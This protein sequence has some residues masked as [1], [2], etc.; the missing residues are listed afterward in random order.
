MSF[1]TYV[2]EEHELWLKRLEALCAPVEELELLEGHPQVL[3]HETEKLR[4]ELR[5]YHVFALENARD[6]VV[7]LVCE[8][9]L[10]LS[11]QSRVR[12]AFDSLRAAQEVELYEVLRSLRPAPDEPPIPKAADL[13]EPLLL[14]IAQRLEPFAPKIKAFNRL[15][16]QKERHQH[17][18]ETR[19][20]RDEQ[21]WPVE[22]RNQLLRAKG[23]I[24]HQRRKTP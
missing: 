8:D 3:N 5:G 2:A 9:P 24:I 16:D 18:A 11:E 12:R 13:M 19:R 4:E 15:F 14:Q 7:I 17:L 6:A 10:T 23:R 20:R 21:P 1:G 22:Q